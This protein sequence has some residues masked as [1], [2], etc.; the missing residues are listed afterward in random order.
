MAIWHFGKSTKARPHVALQVFKFLCYLSI[1]AGT[2]FFIAGKPEVLEAIIRNVSLEAHLMRP[3]LSQ[4]QILEDRI[5]V[6]VLMILIRSYCH[7]AEI[8]RGVPA[9][10]QKATLCRGTE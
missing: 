7:S 8:I 5:S 3:C 1:P 9:R 6:L 2:T 4:C 10:G